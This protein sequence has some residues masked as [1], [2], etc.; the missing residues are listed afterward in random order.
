MPGE[1]TIIVMILAL[2]AAGYIVWNLV[3]ELRGK[4]ACSG[5]GCAAKDQANRES[6]SKLIPVEQ[7][8]VRN[9]SGEH[10]ATSTS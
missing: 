8:R 9:R 10:S 4:G 5:C 3:R 2:L 1:Q 7:I 6:T